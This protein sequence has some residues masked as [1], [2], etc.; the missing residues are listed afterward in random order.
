MAEI[1]LPRLPDRIPVKLT[2]SIAPD[3]HH[4]LSAYAKLY[5]E[6]YGHEEPLTELIPA[7]LASFLESDRA[8]ARQRR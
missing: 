7:M 1:M 6:T 5:A 4:A 8:F 2:I 3:L